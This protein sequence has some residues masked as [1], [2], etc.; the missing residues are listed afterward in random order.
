MRT[1]LATRLHARL[2]RVFPERR[3]FL[4]SDDDMRFIRLRPGTQALATLGGTLV[5]GWT[6]L[7]TAVL[8]IHLT[9]EDSCRRADQAEKEAVGGDRR[10][11]QEDADEP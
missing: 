8:Q 4:K 7:A 1:Q 10:D 2:E 9:I 11:L 3:L 5:V 6:I